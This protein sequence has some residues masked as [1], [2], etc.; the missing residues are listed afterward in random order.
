[1]YWIWPLWTW[2]DNLGAGFGF[3]PLFFQLMPVLVYILWERVWFHWP[4]H[5]L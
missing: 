2:L 3:D 1:M 4:E 5:R